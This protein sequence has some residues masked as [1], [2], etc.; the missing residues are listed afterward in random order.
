MVRSVSASWSLV[1]KAERRLACGVDYLVGERQIVK[2]LICL[3]MG[4]LVSS[5]LALAVGNG[6]PSPRCVL[7][8]QGDRVS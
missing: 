3:V 7:S 1:A 5:S 6:E 4:G 2:G 8:K